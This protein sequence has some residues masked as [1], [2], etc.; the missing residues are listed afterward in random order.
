MLLHMCI[1]FFL[2]FFPTFP[3]NQQSQSMDEIKLNACAEINN[4][5]NYLPSYFLLNLVLEI[6]WAKNNSLRKIV[7]KFKDK[8]ERT[9]WDYLVHL[10]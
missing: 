6:T 2:Q 9:Y 1:Q 10:L 3:P 7:N 4:K 8:S 5:Q